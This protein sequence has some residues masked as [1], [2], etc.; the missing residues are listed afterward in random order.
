MP[1][2]TRLCFIAADGGVH[3]V[4]EQRDSGAFAD[5]SA[6]VPRKALRSGADTVH[7]S[8]YLHRAGADG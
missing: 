2:V 3:P 8:R 6:L 7:L 5:P 4:V 1:A